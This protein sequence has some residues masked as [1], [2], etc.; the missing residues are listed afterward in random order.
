MWVFRHRWDRR[1][2]T[3]EQKR[4]TCSAANAGIA[5]C[6]LAWDQERNRKANKRL[7]ELKGRERGKCSRYSN[8]RHPLRSGVWSEKTKEHHCIM[9]EM[10]LSHGGQPPATHW[11]PR[12]EG[13]LD[14]KKNTENI[15]WGSC[16]WNPA[17][18]SQTRWRAGTGYIHI[19]HNALMS[20]LYEQLLSGSQFKYRGNSEWLW[21]LQKKKR[22]EMQKFYLKFLRYSHW[23]W[24]TNTW[25]FFFS[26]WINCTFCPSVSLVLLE[27]YKSIRISGWKDLWG[28][29]G[30]I[31]SIQECL[32]LSPAQ[33]E[34]GL[35][36]KPPVPWNWQPAQAAPSTSTKLSF[37][38]F[39]PSYWASICL[40]MTS[41]QRYNVAFPRHSKVK[42]HLVTELLGKL[43]ISS[44]WASFR[45]PGLGECREVG[46]ELTSQRSWPW[47][48]ICERNSTCRCRI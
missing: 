4:N 16:L 32:C 44:F 43:Q 40:A 2:E 12:G 13:M 37:R 28:K 10:S 17:I 36:A 21:L 11:V 3:Q 9:A 19:T 45:E 20:S 25:A 6:L 38:K 8:A 29:C 14:A 15:Q 39:Y 30:L 1:R 48:L 41:K 35:P 42:F 33:W 26:L 5:A 46:G 27:D 31:L 22:E 18:S 34:L 24:L 23:Y 7:E 47:G